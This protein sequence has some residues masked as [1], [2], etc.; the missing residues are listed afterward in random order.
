MRELLARR[1][2]AIAGGYPDANDAVRFS[3][4]PMHKMLLDRDP[5]TGRDLASQPTLSRFE[6]PSGRVAHSSPSS[7]LE[8]GLC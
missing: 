3:S 1:I 2:F 6:T 5:A 4:D 7:G 8:W